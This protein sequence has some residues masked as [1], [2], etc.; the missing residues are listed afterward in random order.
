MSLDATIWAWK[1]RIKK[2]KHASRSAVKIVL[3]SLADRAS[4]DHTCFPSI[5]RLEL[6]TE[7]N[8][9]TILAAIR[10]LAEVGL[11]ADTGE[12]KGR[13]KQVKVY[14]LVGV[15]GREEIPLATSGDT[16]KSAENGTV[17]NNREKQEASCT[18][19][20]SQIRNS[21]ENGTVPNLRDKSAE[22]GTAKESQIRDTELPSIELIS[23]PSS[24]P[25]SGDDGKVDFEPWISA[26]GKK[27]KPHQQTIF[28]TLWDAYKHKADRAQ[29]IDSFLKH[30]M[31][32][33]T[34]DPAHNR[35]FLHR[36]LSAIDRHVATRDDDCTPLYFD[37]WIKRR[38]WEDGGDE[39]S[40]G[41]SA[42]IEPGIPAWQSLGFKSADQR[43]EYDS[44][45]IELQKLKAL[46]EPSE[47]QQIIINNLKARLSEIVPV[48][49][50][51]VA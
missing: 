47:A 39:P 30:L 23:E 46:P 16:A 36:L 44:K 28:K 24:A 1:Q 26:K 25:P 17:N 34:Q 18:E 43:A 51:G 9:K 5:S 20:Q 35:A 50:Q 11:I 3:V 40:A 29:A 45:Y 22:N 19:K 41:T 6:D 48:R 31:P 37:R 13:T 42:G 7:L 33:F 12:R 38:R 15:Q 21:T 10:H 8:R 4:E 2:N 14:R 49:Q 32:E 27:L